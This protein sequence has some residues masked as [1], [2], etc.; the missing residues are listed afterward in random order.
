MKNIR[1]RR[2]AIEFSYSL[3]ED[4]DALTEKIVDAMI[5]IVDPDCGT[6]GLP[7]ARSWIAYSEDPDELNE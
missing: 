2:V 5:E 6:D 4:V 3:S 1:Y 7:C